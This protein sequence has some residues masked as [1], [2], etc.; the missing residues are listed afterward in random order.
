[1]SIGNESSRLEIAKECSVLLSQ[2]RQCGVMSLEDNINEIGSG[3]IADYLKYIGNAMC[4]GNP[5]EM[6]A[7]I[8]ENKK[9]R[10]ITEIT[11]KLN[12]IQEG[13]K[14]VQQGSSSS[15]FMNLMESK[16]GFDNKLK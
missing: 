4:D 15:C 1:M 8:S 10:I 2:A 6:L 7:V 5:S 16:Y 13:I 14:H 9:N 11:D 3:F 12:I